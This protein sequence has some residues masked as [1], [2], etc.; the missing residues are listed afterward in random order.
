MGASVP[1]AKDT[2]VERFGHR[3]RRNAYTQLW[4]QDYLFGKTN[5]MALCPLDDDTPATIFPRFLNATLRPTR[6]AS[7]WMTLACHV[8]RRHL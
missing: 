2:A 7:R 8:N 6:R 1:W 3:Y 4:V 5:I